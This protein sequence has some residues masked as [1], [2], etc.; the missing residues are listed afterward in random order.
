MEQGTI[1]AAAVSASMQC[2][3]DNMGKIIKGKGAVIDRVLIALLGSGHVLM[4]DLPGLGKTTLAYCMARSIDCVF[5]RIQFTS[6]LLPS[7]VLG[8]SVYDERTRAFEFKPGPIFSNILLADEINRTT[9]KTQS[10]LLEAMDRGR[11]TVDGVVHT[12]GTPFMVFATQNP[13]DY[14]ATFPLPD[15]QMDRFLVRLQ[16]GYPDIEVERVILS[17][18]SARYDAIELK[19]VIEADRLLEFQ[20]WVPH[21]YVE[22]SVIDYMLQLVTATRTQAEF[23]AGVSTRGSIALKIAAQASA[24]Y[25]GRAFVIPED[26]M[27][28]VLP[29]WTHRLTLRRHASDVLEERHI[30]E[31]ILRRILDS[32]AVP[33]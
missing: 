2:L 7:D 8:V 25:H 27:G 9:P 5:S 18:P 4:E 22:P 14:E 11:I 24:L 6:D 12:L 16:M 33:E 13:V 1:Q 29:V 19:P 15:S 21:V 32:V 28:M 17:H 30:V 23:R 10:A 31:G 20:R 26:V 3:K